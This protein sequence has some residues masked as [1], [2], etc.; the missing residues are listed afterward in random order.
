MIPLDE[1]FEIKEFLRQRVCDINSSENSDREVQREKETKYSLPNDVASFSWMPHIELCSSKNVAIKQI[2]YIIPSLQFHTFL[3]Y[4]LPKAIRNFASMFGTGDAKDVLS[5]LYSVSNY[6]FG[7]INDYQR[8]LRDDNCCYFLLREA[9]GKLSEKLFRLDLFRHI[10]PSKEQPDKYDFIGG[11]MHA[12]RHCSWR[13]MK[14]SCGNGE[15][16]LNSLWDVPV[17]LGEV[18]LCSTENKRT[19]SYK[20]ENETWK[21]EYFIDPETGIYYLTTAFVEHND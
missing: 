19:I 14:L 1:Y 2:L 3:N 20:R 11:L 16:E 4:I 7:D 6:Q 13:N 8:I 15:I 21:I 5:A 10:L 17:L 9:D 18:I 12:Y